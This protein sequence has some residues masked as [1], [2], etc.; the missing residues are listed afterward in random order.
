MK[1]P[2]SLFFGALAPIPSPDAA[3]PGIAD[4]GGGD[5]SEDGVELTLIVHWTCDTSKTIGNLKKH[6]IR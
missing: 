2:A 5:R 1:M 6:I 3:G 4:V